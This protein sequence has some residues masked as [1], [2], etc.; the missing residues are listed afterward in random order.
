MD[1][2]TTLTGFDDFYKQLDKLAKTLGPEIVEPILMDKGTQL[3]NIVRADAPQ[4]KT[5]NLKKGIKVKQMQKRG[6]NPKSVIV[7]S[8][9]PVSH[10]VEYGTSERYQKTTGRY[11]GIMSAHPFFRPA[12]DANE[13]RL[14]NELFD[15]LKKSVESVAE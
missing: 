8:G 7:K 6:D 1:T 15:E 10:L 13:G 3:G 12:V 4:G 11:T 5:G 2:E 14:Y 9:D